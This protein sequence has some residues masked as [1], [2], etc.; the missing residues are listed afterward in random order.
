MFFSKTSKIVA[1]FI[2]VVSIMNIVL[3]YM[4][5]SDPGQTIFSSPGRIIDMSIL[6][7]FAGLALGVL[8]EMSINIKD[9][10]DKF[11]IYYLDDE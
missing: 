5:A 8:T 7:L 11:R 9:Y 2:V 6:S 4:V 3:G 1:Y 10:L